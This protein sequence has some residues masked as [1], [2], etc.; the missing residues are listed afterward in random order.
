VPS[1]RIRYSRTH[2]S[3]HYCTSPCPS[4]KSMVRWMAPL[5][6]CSDTP[7]NHSYPAGSAMHCVTPC[8]ESELQDGKD[9]V[10]YPSLPKA[11]VAVNSAFGKGLRPASEIQL[12]LALCQGGVRTN[13]R[14][15]E[16]KA[17]AAYHRRKRIVVAM[18]TPH[19]KQV[20]LYT[21]P[22]FELTHQS[23]PQN[24]NAHHSAQARSTQVV[25]KRLLLSKFAVRV[26]DLRLL[27]ILD[28]HHQS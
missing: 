11:F 26:L 18:Y 12:F 7:R 2:K 19:L 25:L 22:D 6:A 24:S 4:C 8:S 5:S 20:L 27:P 9:N 3:C 14:V 15:G 21:N 23:Y 13:A 16:Q 10:L 1:N 17:D 28:Q